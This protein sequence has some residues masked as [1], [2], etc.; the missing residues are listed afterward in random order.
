MTILLWFH[1]F[2][3][4]RR[5]GKVRL[6]TAW[7]EVRFVGQPTRVAH[8]Q[9]GTPGKVCWSLVSAGSTKHALQQR[10]SSLGPGSRHRKSGGS[11]ATGIGS[12][13]GPVFRCKSGVGTLTPVSVAG[14]MLG[15]LGAGLAVGGPRFV[16]AVAG[17]G[18]A[19]RS[20]GHAGLVGHVAGSLEYR[21]FTAGGDVAHVA[22]KQCV[23]FPS[24][25]SIWFAGRMSSRNR[26]NSILLL[27][28]FGEVLTCRGQQ[29]GRV[30]GTAPCTKPF[31]RQQRCTKGGSTGLC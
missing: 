11:D 5:R 4:P 12:V 14:D 13:L 17:T 23:R 9:P 15:G 22:L 28:E 21:G 25:A 6:T 18:P 27:R 19:G 10:H 16:Q 1:V 24:R 30:A 29:R 20:S 2:R 7:S 26:L 3:R 31:E 8:F